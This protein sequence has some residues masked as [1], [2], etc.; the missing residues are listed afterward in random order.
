MERLTTRNSVGVAVY[1][2]PYECDRCGEPF[3]RL[4]DDGNGSP[5]D[6]LAELEDLEEQGRLLR[7]PCDIGTRVYK[8]YIA[9][10]EEKP[11][12][13]APNIDVHYIKLE[14]LPV[15]GEKVFLKRSEAE[16]KLAKMVAAHKV[17]L[18]EM[19]KNHEGK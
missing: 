16:R 15:M 13:Y 10:C 9:V 1:K 5:T 3:Y 14:D 11:W 4:P 18:K 2:H 12:L 19:E 17:K 6:K 8:P 7:L